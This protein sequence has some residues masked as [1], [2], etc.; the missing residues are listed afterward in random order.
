MGSN[1]EKMEAQ[2]KTWDAKFNRLNRK[3]QDAEA[4]AQPRIEYHK[5]VNM[6]KAKRAAAQ[7]KFEEFK[8]AGGEKW[9]SLKDGIEAAWKDLETAFKELIK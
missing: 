8:A 6:I 7:A 1:L 5:R 9:N 2:L 4:E 3:D